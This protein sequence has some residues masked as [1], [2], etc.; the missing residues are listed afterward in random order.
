MSISRGW[1]GMGLLVATILSLVLPAGR[2]AAQAPDLASMDVVQRSVPDGPVALVFKTPVSRDAFLAYYENELGSLSAAMRK[3]DF[4]DGDRVK[5]AIR[6]LARLIQRELLYQ[7][8]GKRGLKVTDAEVEKACQEDMDV[9]KQRFERKDGQ[10]M[11]ED[12]VMKLTGRTPEE[13]RQEVQR[14]L[15]IDKAFDA[16]IKEQ[17]VKVSAAEIDQFR[18][19]NPNLFQRPD[20]M[21]LRQ[22]YCR[23][24]AS[25]KDASPEQ[26]AEARAQAEKALARIRAGESFEAVAKSMSQA[27]DGKRGGDMGNLPAEQIP[28]FYRQAVQGMKPDEISGVIESEYGYH[29][30]QFLGSEGGR[31]VTP[32]ESEPEIREILERSKTE[33]AIAT[34]SEP[35]MNDPEKVQIFLHLEQTLAATPEEPKKATPEEPKKKKK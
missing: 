18:K 26:K 4:S 33:L 3:T 25:M 27:P 11:T 12:D 16:I 24:K 20:T 6:C 22:V 23:P 19:E 7:E 15:L 29:V 9:M 13:I 8:A 32:E 17:G 30:I 28:P 14:S 5:V 1:I 31:A 35:V 21:H 34:W 2:A 10:A